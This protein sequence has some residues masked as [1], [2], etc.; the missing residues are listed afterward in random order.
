MARRGSKGVVRQPL[1]KLWIQRNGC[2]EVDAVGYVGER[3]R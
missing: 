1:E 2:E 3:R